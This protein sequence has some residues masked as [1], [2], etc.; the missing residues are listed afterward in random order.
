LATSAHAIVSLNSRS[1]FVWC[2][3]C[4]RAFAL[5]GAGLLLLLLLLLLLR[6]QSK[7]TGAGVGRE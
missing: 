1:W 6:G 4:R 2:G 5:G 3:R 7:V